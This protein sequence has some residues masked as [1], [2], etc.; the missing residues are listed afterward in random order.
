M[1]NLKPVW[2][3][4]L[5]VYSAYASAC[6]K[7]NV[8]HWAAYG[9][10][11][12]AVRHKGFIPW[13]D[14]FD[15]FM[16]RD[17][18]ERFLARAEEYLP[19]YLKLV[20]WRNT[21]EYDF[22]FAKVQDTRRDVYDRVVK[23]SGTEQP[24]GLYIDIFPLD[25]VAESFWGRLREKLVRTLAY[26]RYTSL[27]RKGAHRGLKGWVGELLGYLLAP[28]FGKFS[29]P[30]DFD[31]LREQIAERHPFA[32]SKSCGFYFTLQGGW[33][34][35]GDAVWFNDTVMLPFMDIVVPA[36]VKWHEC[37]TQMYG[38]YMT[39]PPEPDRKSVHWG[40]APWKFGPTG[41]L[42]RSAGGTG[43]AR[44]CRASCQERSFKRW[45]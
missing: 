44:R 31:L 11:L 18:Y 4:I 8:R 3:A 34:W 12:G 43:L 36:P 33:E 13:D 9:T 1:Q 19:S 22:A 20:T 5:D 40:E 37:L 17:D 24:Q 45:V 42:D 32:G 14:D 23:E 15:V 21:K 7:L 38:D 29:S 35:T 26:A 28:W 16:P 10:L 27:F 39:P 2:L 6:E 30:K 25:G 41:R